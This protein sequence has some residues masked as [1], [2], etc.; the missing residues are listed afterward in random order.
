MTERNTVPESAKHMMLEVCETYE[1]VERTSERMTLADFCEKF[2]VSQNDLREILDPKRND[3]YRM[4][5]INASH[6]RVNEHGSSKPFERF[7][8]GTIDL[9]REEDFDFVW[10]DWYGEGFMLNIYKVY[11]EEDTEQLS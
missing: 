10:N 8:N 6:D 11:P 9:T 7:L 3:F 5:A 1:G 4:L 2:I